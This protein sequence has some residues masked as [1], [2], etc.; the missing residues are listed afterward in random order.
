MQ[1]E[2]ITYTSFWGGNS[3]DS[4]SV[5]LIFPGT[6]QGTYAWNE[7]DS[8][9]ALVVESG[10]NAKIFFSGNNGQTVITSYGQIGG[11][12]KGKFDGYLYTETGDSVNVSSEFDV[13][14]TAEVT[15]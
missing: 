1:Q 7:T 4:V 15:E 3:T 6:Q 2:N 12:L 5:S 10:N 14:R 11:R 9:I 13:L 8:G